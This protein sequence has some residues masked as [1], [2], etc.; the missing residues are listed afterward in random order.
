MK[1][2]NPLS[3]GALLLILRIVLLLAHLYF[4]EI[5]FLKSIVIQSMTAHFRLLA[6]NFTLLSTNLRACYVKYQTI[7]G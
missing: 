1:E 2:K 3:M 5:V 6:K 4:I 7:F